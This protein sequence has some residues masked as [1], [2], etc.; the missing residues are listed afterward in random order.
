MHYDEQSLPIITLFSKSFCSAFR[1][2]FTEWDTLLA[3]EER[4]VEEDLDQ[5]PPIRIRHL[6]H[7]DLVPTT[8]RDPQYCI[9]ALR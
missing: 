8:L 3:R 6:P 4:L 5:I 7:S 1:S 2:S 9:G